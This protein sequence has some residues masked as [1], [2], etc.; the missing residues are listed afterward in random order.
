VRRPLAAAL[1]LVVL[2]GACGGDDGSGGDPDAVGFTPTTT[3]VLDEDEIRL[4]QRLLREQ[5][6]RAAGFEPVVLSRRFNAE[7]AGRILLC[8][9]DL[10]SELE[11]VSGRQSRFS[12]GEVELSHTVTSGGDVASFLERF[13]TV[14]EDCPRPWTEP[15]LPVGGG[16]V[17]REITG[18]YPLPAV[19]ADGAGAIIRSHNRLGATDTI[20][21]VLVDGL[22]V[23]SL[24][25]SGPVGAD[26]SVV[27][28]AVMAADQRLRAVGALAAGAD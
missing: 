11:I 15:P 9:E 10:R 4:G 3:E 5:D 1:A 26:F 2:A 6:L 8:D 14:V 12:D 17:G 24:S 23:S 18:T 19:A 20:V 28:D 25:V 21:I 7:G 16:P 22:V 13:R 27:D